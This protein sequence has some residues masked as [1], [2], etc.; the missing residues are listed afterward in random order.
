MPGCGSW[1]G[2]AATTV[3]ELLDGHVVLDVECLD[4]IYLNAYVP[5][6]Q[7]GGQVVG[8][9]TRH[10]GLPIPSPAV[11]E[12]IGTAFRR[13]VNTFAA[14]HQVPIVKFGKLDR[15][16]EVMLPYLQRQAATGVPGV[17]AIG[18]AQ[19]YQNVF[20]SSERVDR[21][22]TGHQVWFT[23]HKADRRVTCFYFYLVGQGVRARVHQDLRLLPLPGQGLGQRPR[24]GQAAG[25]ARRDRVQRTVQWVRHL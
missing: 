7:V 13:A 24:V 20:A 22:Y 10:L 3:N 5:K 6:L 8:F 2:V 12:K 11:M 16:A 18:V 9:M 17:A 21:G 14:A 23:F 25:P 19:E 4:R 1:W 15:K